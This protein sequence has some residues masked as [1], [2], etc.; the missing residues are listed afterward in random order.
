MHARGAGWA[1]CW[2][3]PLVRSHDPPPNHSRANVR[4]R[5]IRLH[6]R[7]RGAIFQGAIMKITLLVTGIWMLGYL[8]PEIM[9][10]FGKARVPTAM[11][12]WS[13]TGCAL[14]ALALLW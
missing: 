4:L 14:I 7:R 9:A 13:G 1:G 3:V 8:L 2:Q 11:N 12:L 10:V 5:L 6:H